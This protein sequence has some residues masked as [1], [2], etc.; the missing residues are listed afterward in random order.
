MRKTKLQLAVERQGQ[1]VR[2][3]QIVRGL[4]CDL[5]SKLHTRLTAE[6]ITFENKDFLCWR[7]NSPCLDAV[8]RQAVS[9]IG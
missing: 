4:P 6:L 1:P 3:G 9:R 7:I 2:K 8:A 5:C